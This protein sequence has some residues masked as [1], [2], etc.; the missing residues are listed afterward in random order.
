MPELLTVKC[1]VEGRSV[2]QEGYLL[3]VC[4]GLP[5]ATTVMTFLLRQESTDLEHITV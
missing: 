1:C 4:P 3:L 2:F 5:E